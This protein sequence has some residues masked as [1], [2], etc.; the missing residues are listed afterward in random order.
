[1]AMITVTFQAN[2]SEAMKERSLET[3]KKS[4]QCV[5]IELEKKRQHT[6]VGG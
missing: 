3:R 1:M 5:R 2:V 4:H 6:N